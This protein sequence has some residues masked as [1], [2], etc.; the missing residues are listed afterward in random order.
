MSAQSA[1]YGAIFPKNLRLRETCTGV[2][3]YEFYSPK[4]LQ[5]LRATRLI[6]KN[7]FQKHAENDQYSIPQFWA[8]FTAFPSCEERQFEGCALPRVQ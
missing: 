1:P 7:L 6:Q 3:K 4:Y 8:I 2:Y 5:Q